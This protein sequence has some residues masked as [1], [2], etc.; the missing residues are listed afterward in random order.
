MK[1]IHNICPWDLTYE[2]K[3]I[4]NNKYARKLIYGNIQI[5]ENI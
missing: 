2:W 5:A 4:G 1:I 3:P